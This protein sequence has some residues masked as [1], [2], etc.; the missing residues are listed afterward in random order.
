MTAHKETAAHQE[1]GVRHRILSGVGWGASST[2]VTMGVRFGQMLVVARLLP[3]GEIGLYALSNLV[4]G[5]VSIFADAGVTQG[6]V[7]RRETD[8]GVLSS[9][10]WTNTLLALAVSAILVTSAPLL[11]D[12]YGTP[13]LATPLTLIASTF[14]AFALSQPFQALLQRELAFRAIALAET[15][16]TVVGAAASI[17]L[18]IAGAGV[19]GLVLGQ[20]VYAVLRSLL[21]VR[22][23]SAHFR[24][25]LHC[26]FAEAAP[27]MRFGL[28]QLGDRLLGYFNTKLD[29]MLI[30][31]LLG[32]AALG[33]YALAWSLV[34]EPVYRLNPIVTNVAFPA[35][36]AKQGDQAALRRGFFAM[37]RALTMVNAP[38][39]AG[40]AG[41]AA[42][43][44]PMALGRRW[45]EAVPLMAILAWIGLVR[46]VTNPV[47]SL[48]MGV[49][50]P[51]LSFRWTLAQSV[52]QL[53]L[54][55]LLLAEFGLVR[56]TL[57]LAGLMNLVVPMMYLFLVRRILGP[58]GI[59]YLGSFLPPAL[60][61]GTMGLGVL[62]IGRA[63]AGTL[64]LPVLF[65]LQVVAGLVFYL[66]AYALLRPRDLRAAQ[67]YLVARLRRGTAIPPA[68]PLPV[69]LPPVGET[70]PMPLPAI[71]VVIPT[72]N[73]AHTIL[74]ALESV[75]AQTLPVA[76]II[77]VD[78]GSTDGTLD[79]LQS[80]PY[81]D[82]VRLIEIRHGG[83]AAARN[84][85]IRAATGDW[86]AFLDSDDAWHPEKLGR[87][88]ERLTLLGPEYD[89][90]YCGS[91]DR[92]ESG[93]ALGASRSAIEGAIYFDSLDFNLPGA[94]S[95]IVARR[96]LLLALG[97][98]VETLPACQDWD[99]WL[100]LARRSKF[101]CVPQIL[102]TLYVGRGDRIT[103][104]PKARL[105]GHLH[106]YRT[107]TRPAL[108]EG[109]VELSVFYATLG[110]I[111]M[112]LGRP[113]QA[114]RCYMLYWR[115]K[116]LSSKRAFYLFTALS[117][118]PR[119]PFFAL[120]SWADRLEAR[121]RSSPVSATAK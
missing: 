20:I 88:L 10:F 33:L 79:L 1:T 30:G 40:M 39:L 95:C 110:Q 104:N 83:A 18:T 121:V 99:L 51:D 98:F 105:R 9:L 14:L 103:A 6:I 34:V 15:V 36:A 57:C 81:R 5:F 71:S 2:A 13:R 87:Q 23:G 91:A 32:P 116:K 46:A 35:F 48:V 94:T 93:R 69:G 68:D 26:R 41:T 77:I 106:I 78:D 115:G 75:L 53:P 62:L 70:A 58:S 12:L 55:A 85:G 3:P 56:A 90:C 42:V 108:R 7:A 64:P 119:G 60:A 86:V 50:R 114:R 17:A 27:S 8:R 45:Q 24:P 38:I 89:A 37:T 22:A 111:F 49:G 112:Q 66:A 11:A 47:G 113:A 29:Q 67:T 25:R 74:R 109:A 84:I 44:V 120:A 100:R 76:E 63:G 73:R 19:T 107:Y 52:V 97:G 92:D 117:G 31:F 96:A 21:I 80:L 43:F 54:Y 118:L 72:Y 59:A 61:A 28:F 82:R 65:A 102:V 4:L 16:A 101:A